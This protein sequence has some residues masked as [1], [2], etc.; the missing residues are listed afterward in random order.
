MKKYLFVIVV[1]LSAYIGKSTSLIP[2]KPGKPVVVK[3]RRHCDDGFGFC[4]LIPLWKVSLSDKSCAT[5]ETFYDNEKLII[6]IPRNKLS[7]EL[8]DQFESNDNFPVDEDVVLPDDIIE[9]LDL[10][11]NAVLSHGKY[12]IEKDMDF[13][14]IVIPVLK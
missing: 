13:F 9:Q 3:I 12:T 1:L 4:M 8:V 5:A 11:L 7:D 14:R 2:A 10:P 6:I